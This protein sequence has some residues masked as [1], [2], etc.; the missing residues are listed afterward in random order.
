[1]YHIATFYFFVREDVDDELDALAFRVRTGDME[2]FDLMDV[3][4]RPQV[5]R[6]SYRYMNDF[7]DREDVEQEMM[8]Q[9]LRLCSR[10]QH[11]RGRYRHYLFRTLHLEMRSRRKRGM[12]ECSALVPVG[13][14][15]VAEPADPEEKVAN[16]INI[17][18]KEEQL[19]YL[20]HKRGVCSP[21]E[22]KVLQ[23]LEKGH[24]IS[25]VCSEF[26]LDRKSVL[27][28]LHRIRRKKERLALMEESGEPFDN[29]A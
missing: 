17:M 9:A 15:G 1:M 4:L 10:Y 28:T 5:H 20:M 24:G 19:Q 6:M 14:K 18:V 27:N 13:E 22:R 8:E 7:H 25:D 12:R 3:K 11:D 2:A 23:H 21:L 26:A 16:P 29:L